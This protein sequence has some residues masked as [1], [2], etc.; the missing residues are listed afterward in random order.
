MRRLTAVLL[1]AALLV[2]ATFAAAD[3]PFAAFA[4]VADAP[5][6]RGLKPTRWVA[7][8]RTHYY[9][10]PP[11]PVGT[12]VAF[13]GCARYAKAFFPWNPEDCQECLGFPEH[14]SQTKQAL[15]L[16]Y[17]MLALEP[18]DF[19]HLCWSSSTT[20]I[21]LN[22]QPN[23]T[24][25]IRSFVS[26]Q[27]LRDKP[28]YLLGT[29]SGG[30]L[31]LKLAAAL[32]KEAE[33]RDRAQQDR[34]EAGQEA[35]A[36]DEE[37]EWLPRISGVI[38]EESVPT[39]FNAGD[40]DGKL[41]Y[42]SYPP[43]IFVLMDGGN[44]HL[45]APQ[46]V[47]FLEDGGVP[48]A[49]VMSTARAV[50]PTYLSDR[51]P[52]IT[53]FQSGLI[54]GAMRQI[55]MLDANGWLLGDPERNR[56]V[57]QNTSSPA[58]DWDLKLKYLLPWLADNSPTLSLVYRN[59]SIQQAL[60]VA[61]SR[62]DAISDFMTVALKWLEAKGKA[63]VDVLVEQY[64]VKDFNLTALTVDRG[65]ATPAK[66]PA[67]AVAPEAQPPAAAAG[68]PAPTTA[69]GAAAPATATAAAA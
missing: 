29:S 66:A 52:A 8:G 24:E 37:Q 6:N 59:C 18:S 28:L 55:G 53:P 15:A 41:R 61:Y 44:S 47:K 42:R 5:T 68:A 30:T 38:S 26:S 9:Q 12:V 7:F 67:P 43:T 58:T 63:D 49:V 46:V 21:Y 13:H 32:A 27:G 22:D 36:A 14:V 40:A 60:N 17:A 48:A 11:N 69:T 20:G 34:Q 16:G 57:R 65:P 19:R 39:N 25:L 10:V 2:A 51:I 62:H 4:P 33:A 64:T 50:T 45:D 23:A 3:D 31:A 1:A 56:I 35:A 54:A